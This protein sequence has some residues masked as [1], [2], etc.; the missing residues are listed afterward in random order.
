MK[1]LKRY[2]II[3]VLFLC[4]CWGFIKILENI[5]LNNFDDKG[6]TF[7]DKYADV[8]SY[9][10]AKQYESAGGMWYTQTDDLYHYS[11]TQCL[12]VWNSY[13]LLYEASGDVIWLEKLS[14]QIDNILD[15]RDFVIHK[16]DR[17][18][19]SLPSWSY[20]SDIDLYESYHNPVMIGLIVYPMLRFVEVV[21]DADVKRFQK[22]SDE[23][24]K[25]SLDALSV[26]DKD[27]DAF[28]SFT[29]PQNACQD[30]WR[31]R[32]FSGIR[33]GYYVGH[34]YYEQET[35]KENGF[36]SGNPLPYNQSLSVAQCYPVLYRLL[37]DS[38]WLEK[39][40]KSWNWFR[41]TGF[42]TSSDVWWWYYAEYYNWCRNNA[43]PIKMISI[44]VDKE[45]YYEDYEGH[46]SIDLN[47]IIEA[48]KI[49]VIDDKILAEIN[50][51]KK[52]MGL[53]SD[54]WLKIMNTES[55]K[56]NN[57]LKAAVYYDYFVRTLKDADYLDI[58]FPVLRDEI[59]RQYQNEIFADNSTNVN[60]TCL[61][62][63]VSAYISQN[64][65]LQS[66]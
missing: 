56:S 22:K 57:N 14:D 6:Y 66:K 2:K 53:S 29:I 39:T 3:G 19:M 65:K 44:P 50:K 5:S 36:V 64:E 21:K 60:G 33:L 20:T 32:T 11:W 27:V 34:N 38:I 25:A 7:L 45:G 52:E 46:Y 43:I 12:N 8:G 4:V 47:F 58:V 24:L 37:G 54:G 55:D 26:I 15:K 51:N 10:L 9:E 48:H 41:E 59:E 42:D 62:L 23:Y 31:E 49:G 17:N 63:I 18:G 30:M 16:V 61:R 40:K 1:A 13:I 28:D 35:F